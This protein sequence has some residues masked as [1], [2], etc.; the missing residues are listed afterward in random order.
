M[1]FVFHNHCYEFKPQENGVTGWETLMQETDPEAGE[2]GV[3]SVLAD[4]GRAGPRV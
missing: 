3:R 2:A 4:P 1:E